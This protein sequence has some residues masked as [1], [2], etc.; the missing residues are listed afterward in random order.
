MKWQ[1]DITKV[2]CGGDENPSYGGS[3]KVPESK[4]EKEH[5]QYPMTFA[6]TEWEWALQRKPLRWRPP[7][8]NENER[9]SDDLY[10]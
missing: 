1:Y 2:A 4:K 5:G 10:G 3:P 8:N 7:E 6:F 9:K